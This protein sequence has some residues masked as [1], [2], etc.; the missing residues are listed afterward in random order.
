MTHSV[1]VLGH[2]HFQFYTVQT[3]DADMKTP[4]AEER[5][6][7]FAE[8]RVDPVCDDGS[9]LFASQALIIWAGLLGRDSPLSTLSSGESVLEFRDLLLEFGDIGQNR[10]SDDRGFLL[11]S[12]PAS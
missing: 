12:T 1:G 11:L 5:D 10:P 2:R 6:S 3:S 4:R 9:L 7:E 8:S